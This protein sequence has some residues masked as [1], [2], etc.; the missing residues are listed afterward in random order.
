[1]L[2]GVRTHTHTHLIEFIHPLGTNTAIRPDNEDLAFGDPDKTQTI[3]LEGQIKHTSIPKMTCYLWNSGPKFKTAMHLC[4]ILDIHFQLVL[5]N[6]C[7]TDIEHVLNFD[8][9]RFINPPQHSE[10][11]LTWFGAVLGRA[12]TCISST[13]GICSLAFKVRV[14]PAGTGCGPSTRGS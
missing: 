11:L 13:E 14:S 5:I 7:F 12:H 8:K 2:F 3:D 4:D 9:K 10:K 1:M 6:L